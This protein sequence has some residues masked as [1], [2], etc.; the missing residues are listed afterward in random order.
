MQ[1]RLSL[2]IFFIYV[3]APHAF[4][5]PSENMC[6]STRFLEKDLYH[7]FILTLFKSCILCFQ[8]FQRV[9]MSSSISSSQS[10]LRFQSS[11]INN[12]GSRMAGEIIPKGSN[13][14]LIK[15]SI[16]RFAFGTSFYNTFTF[17][18]SLFGSQRIP[19]TLSSGILSSLRS[20][21][22]SDKMLFRSDFKILDS[23]I[24]TL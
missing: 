6:S 17:G 24:K 21:S 18:T 19:K 11:W 12:F 20:T 9:R 5:D 4:S 13:M 23:S 14:L 7:R 1:L 16:P 8:M 15:L 10:I 3:T 2:L 22:F